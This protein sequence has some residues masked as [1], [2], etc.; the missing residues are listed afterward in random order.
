MFVDSFLEYLRDERQY[1]DNTVKSYREDLMQFVE[2]VKE[3]KDGIFNPVEVD[4]DIVRNWIMSLMESKMAP[5]TVNRKLSSLKSFF[6]YLLKKKVI[7]T[8]PVR[9]VNGPKCGKKLPSFVRDDDMDG[10][11]DESQ[12]ENDFKGVRDRLIL[13]LIY[14]TGLRR[15][16]VVSIVRTD[17]DLDEMT[18]RVTGKGN[19]QRII[20][21]ASRLKELFS[22]YEQK[23]S[24]EVGWDDAAYF[25]KENGFPINASFVYKVV[26][27]HLSSVPYLKKKSPHVLRHS[28]ATSMLNNGAELEA[29]K[30]ILGHSSLASTSVYTHTTFEELK[31]NYH[32]HPRAKKKE[33]YYGN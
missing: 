2:F 19:K 22:Q 18:L 11:L 9:L 24:D 25:V 8:S 13:E 30:Q 33:V 20:P 4:K 28:F 29:V 21:F 7:R 26:T 16:E 15:S 5:T 14:D 10:V 6:K 3:N 23:R 12:F 27:S 31:K 1:S 32:A 17:I